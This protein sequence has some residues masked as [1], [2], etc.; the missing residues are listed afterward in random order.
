MRIGQLA[1]RAGVTADTI[2]FYERQGLLAPARRTPSRYREYDREALEELR[3]IK[4]AQ[5]LGLRLDDIREV[6]EISSGG[7]PPCDHVRAT[8]ETRLAEVEERLRD[9]NELRGTLRAALRRLDRTPVPKRGCRCAVI[10][11]L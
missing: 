6:M 9:L 8:L 11:S 3:F 2:R 7:K 1:E 10:E 5:A 4:K